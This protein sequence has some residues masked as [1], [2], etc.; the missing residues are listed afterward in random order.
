MANAKTAMTALET[1]VTGITTDLAAQQKIMDDNAGDKAGQ[2]YKDAKAQFDTLTATKTTKQAELTTKKA[3]RDAWVTAQET[4]DL[5][6]LA[7][8][9]AGAIAAAAAA[10]ADLTTKKAMKATAETAKAA[11]EQA[12]QKALDAKKGAKDNA[13]W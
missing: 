13:E 5:A 1:A 10:T 2:K 4:E 6:D 12:Y 8:Q 11:A 3:E 7:A 9:E